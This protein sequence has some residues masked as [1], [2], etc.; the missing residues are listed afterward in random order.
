MRVQLQSESETRPSHERNRATIETGDRKA[1]VERDVKWVS[2]KA[3]VE[4]TKSGN[5][6]TLKMVTGKT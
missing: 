1:E 4:A 6:N 3:E 2:A 5:C